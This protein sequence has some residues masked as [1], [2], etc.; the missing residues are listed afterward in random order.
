[1]IKINVLDLPTKFYISP[2]SPYWYPIFI[3]NRYLKQ[4]GLSFKFFTSIEEKLNECDCLFVSSRY[5]HLE[6]HRNSEK[7]QKLEILRQLREHIKKIVWF[8]LRDSTGNTQ[9]EVLP[10]V[11]RYLKKQ[12]LKDWTLYQKKLYGNRIYTQYFHENFNIYDNYDEQFIP[13]RSEERTKIGI[14]WNLGLCDHRNGG[15]LT[16]LWNLVWDRIERLFCLQ[17]RMPWI[18][19]QETRDINLL[20]LFRTEYERKTISFQRMR[21]LHLLKQIQ[22]EK[23]WVGQKITV[24]KYQ[25]ALA[26]SKIVLSLFGWGEI[27]HRDFEAFTSG[28]S[29]LMPNVSHL[30]SWPEL[31]VPFLTYWP[32]QWDLSDLVE[33]YNFLLSHEKKRIEIAKEGQEQYKKLWTNEG[34]QKFC[35]RLK[36]FIVDVIKN[37]GIP[38]VNTPYLREVNDK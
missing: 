32:I 38:R 5:L 29:L 7:T 31:H 24:R 13:L 15:K 22:D 12:I 33:S 20:A 18:S 14:S 16:R 3:N 25:N 35:I 28:A 36:D 19:H 37:D 2:V 26:R 4:L 30:L 34:R 6:K 1:M 9:F 10:Y 21:A 8:D 17:H 27:C 11:S 23:I